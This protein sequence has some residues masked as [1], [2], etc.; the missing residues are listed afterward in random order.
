MSDGDEILAGLTARA[1]P[2]HTAGQLAIELRAGGL[3]TAD[4]FHQPMQIVR[5]DWNS[6]FCEVP[7]QAIATRRR[8]LERALAEQTVLFPSHPGAPHAGRVAGT[9]AHMR[10]APLAAEELT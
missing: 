3:F 5:P 8:L 10:F 4:V 7:A 6:R 9:A 2:G 1:A